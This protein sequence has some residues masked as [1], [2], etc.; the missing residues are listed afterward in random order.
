[1]CRSQS[2]EQ[3]KGSHQIRTSDRNGLEKT[4]R[5][6]YS[7]VHLVEA[8]AMPA[9]LWYSKEDIA[10]FRADCDRS[11]LLARVGFDVH[12]IASCSWGIEHTCCD[13]VARQRMNRRQEAWE[14]V[15]D[16]Q[17]CQEEYDEFALSELYQDV[18]RESQMEAYER[19]QQYRLELLTG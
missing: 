9:N 17:Y 11:G 4:V 12:G 2:T 7:S 18:T 8:L 3:A 6:A 1:M 15:I 19:A 16:E 13:E 5:W 14:A 10:A